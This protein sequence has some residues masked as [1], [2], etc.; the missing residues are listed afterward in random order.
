MQ[1]RV[2]FEKKSSVV[3]E[4]AVSTRWRGLS[5]IVAGGFHEL[6]D[7][8]VMTCSTFIGL[9]RR[10]G[11]RAALGGNKR[12]AQFFFVSPTC[13]RGDGGHPL[14]KTLHAI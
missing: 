11:E 7:G 1:E 9:L 4:L 13:R 5:K 8:M 2:C 10:Y 3:G 12:F 6:W 14:R